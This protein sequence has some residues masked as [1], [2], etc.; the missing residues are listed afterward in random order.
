MFEEVRGFDMRL[1]WCYSVCLAVFI[2]RVYVELGL[3][4]IKIFFNLF[5][6]K[7]MPFIP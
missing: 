3:I 7:I 2:P 4:E 1:A 5:Y 6:N